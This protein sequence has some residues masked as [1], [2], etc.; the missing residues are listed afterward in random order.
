MVPGS[1]FRGCNERRFSRAEVQV[2]NDETGS[3]ATLVPGECAPETV[4]CPA[5]PL[6]QLEV[7]FFL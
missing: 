4:V 3:E 7:V 1:M 2:A 5:E 6:C